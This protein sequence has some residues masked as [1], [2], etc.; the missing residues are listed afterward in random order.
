MDL[1]TFPQ[2]KMPFKKGSPNAKIS[3]LLL[4]ISSSNGE[5]LKRSI[6]LT[7]PKKKTIAIFFLTLRIHGVFRKAFTEALGALVKPKYPRL[8]IFDIQ[9]LR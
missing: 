1:Q 9:R 2:D 6:Y 7:F 4:Y 3:G 5:H 8:L